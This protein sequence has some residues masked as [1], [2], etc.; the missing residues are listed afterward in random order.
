M[1]IISGSKR[2]TKLYGPDEYKI[3]PTTDRS[4][5]SLFNIINQRIY[6]SNFLDLFAGTGAIGLEAKS[7]GAECVICV[8]KLQESI[9]IIKEN[10]NKTK[11]E[12]CVQKSDVETF[13]KK[14]NI[15]FDIIFLDPPYLY[16]NEY[17]S[18]VIDLIF[19]RELLKEDGMIIIE[20]EYRK[21][22]EELFSMY[23]FVDIRKYGKVSFIFI[24]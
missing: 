24:K 8:D 23:D 3:R 20:R 11:L 17:V 5:E 13:I 22:N 12:V 21:E 2:G 10:V 9:N 19:Q 1:R 4:K 18:E 15:K 7:R 14:T 6:N 16:T